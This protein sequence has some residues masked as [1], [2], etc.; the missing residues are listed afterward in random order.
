MADEKENEEGVLSHPAKW[1]DAHPPERPYVGVVPKGDVA[2]IGEPA[3]S[4]EA[5]PLGENELEADQSI[6]KDYKDV[7]EI[8]AEGGVGKDTPKPLQMVGDSAPTDEE[9]NPKVEK[10]VVVKPVVKSAKKK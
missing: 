7:T 8:E 2:E 1:Q 10:K 9:L 4:P 5:P 6:T 3:R